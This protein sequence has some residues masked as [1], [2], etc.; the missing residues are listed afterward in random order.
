MKLETTK[1]IAVI[2]YETRTANAT[3]A[4]EYTVINGQLTE[5]KADVIVTKPTE[6]PDADGNPM[7]QDVE[8]QI[9]T[10]RMEYQVLRTEHFPY[11]EDLPKYMADFCEIVKSIVAPDAE[12]V[13]EAETVDAEEE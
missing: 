3:Y 2:G 4:G 13:E 11:S 5:V 8:Q 10:L 1:Q 12:V 6:V 9:G 7:V